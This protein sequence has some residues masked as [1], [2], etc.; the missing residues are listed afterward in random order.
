MRINPQGTFGSLGVWI[1]RTAA[2]TYGF[3][4]ATLG[5]NEKLVLGP[6]KLPPG[7]GISAVW[8]KRHQF[9]TLGYPLHIALVEKLFAQSN[10]IDVMVD[11]VTGTWSHE[12][13]QLHQT[14][15]CWAKVGN[16]R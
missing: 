14:R 4:D 2:G 9:D 12:L 3:T 8:I 15:V 13:G 7:S 11:D 10:K 6:P 16:Q 1:Y 5:T